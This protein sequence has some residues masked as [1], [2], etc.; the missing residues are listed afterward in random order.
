MYRVI[1]S[2]VLSTD[3]RGLRY[4]LDLVE[5]FEAYNR[6]AAFE[7]PECSYRSAPTENAFH[8][9]QQA[10]VLDCFAEKELVFHLDAGHVEQ[11]G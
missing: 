3:I 8:Y 5:R 2:R 4:Y 1:T 6:M 7:N 9:R 10:V 11:I